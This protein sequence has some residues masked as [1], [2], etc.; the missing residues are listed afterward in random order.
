MALDAGGFPVT[1]TRAGVVRAARATHELAVID[2][3]ISG[4]Y[5]CPRLVA[6]R[7]QA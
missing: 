6:W 7:G 4:C 3:R 5:A 1:R 2:E